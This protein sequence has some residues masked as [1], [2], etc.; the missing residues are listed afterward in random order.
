MNDCLYKYRVADKN[1]LEILI[2]RKLYL[3]NTTQFNDPFD[4]QLLPGDFINELKSLGY[5]GIENDISRHND[6]VKDRINSHGVT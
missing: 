6:F 2:N 4:G 1:G 3:A 5:S